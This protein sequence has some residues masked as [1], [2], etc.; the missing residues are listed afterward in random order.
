[1]FI[2]SNASGVYCHQCGQRRLLFSAMIYHSHSLLSIHLPNISTP[3]IGIFVKSILNANLTFIVHSNIVHYFIDDNEAGG[4]WPEGT[5][6]ITF[7]PKQNNRPLFKGAGNS[8][9]VFWS[10]VFA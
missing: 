1:M 5:R 2:M 9:R 4:D 7:F 10:C 8:F 3:N 6:V